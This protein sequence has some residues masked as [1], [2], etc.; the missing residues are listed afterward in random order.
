[1]LYCEFLIV[2][3]YEAKL[4]LNHLNERRAEYNKTS[5]PL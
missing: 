4:V 2:R 1:M 3:K 5:H